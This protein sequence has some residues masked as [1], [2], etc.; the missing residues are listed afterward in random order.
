MDWEDTQVLNGE[1][2]EYLTTVRKDR[3]SDD[4]YLGSMT[5]KDG[6]ELTLNLEFLGEG[7]YEAQIYA[8]A[9]GISWENN[10]EEVVI[11]KQKVNLNSTLELKLAPGGGAA[12][13]FKKL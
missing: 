12:I 13:R 2:G 1:I 11:S 3:N 9:P 5:N 7:N 10:P 4:W 6:R 8:D